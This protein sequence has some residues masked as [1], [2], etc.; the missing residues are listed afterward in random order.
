MVLP[1]KDCDVLFFTKQGMVKR[2]AVSEYQKTRGKLLACGLKGTDSVM[3]AVLLPQ[4]CELILVAKKTNA[5][6]FQ[7]DSIPQ[8]GRTAAGVKA[9]VLEAGDEVLFA[10]LL[11]E[12]KEMALF[13]D[14]GYAKRLPIEE[15]EPQKRNGKGQKVLT[16]PKDGANG[17][18][19]VFVCWV[20]LA[21]KL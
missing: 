2:T 13:T 1:E 17:N 21:G 3:K 8:Q 16:L 11:H 19:L 4:N 14:R 12:Q 5:I 10:D 7:T 6:R 18:E 15:I 9:I 20:Q